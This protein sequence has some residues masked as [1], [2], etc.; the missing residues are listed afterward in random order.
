M[1]KI[2]IA[3]ICHFSNTNIRAK[4]PLS[5]LWV[6][7]L[8]KKLIGKNVSNYEDFAPW[9]TTI[10]SEFEKF[11]DVEL[12]VISPH[13]GLK[14]KLNEFSSNNIHYHFFKPVMPFIQIKWRSVFKNYSAPQYRCNREMVSQIVN[15][16]NPE[17]VN[18]FGSENPYYSIT[19]LDIKKIP[20]NVL[21]QSVLYTPFKEKYNFVVE[22]NRLEIERKIFQ[23]CFYFGTACRM[24]SDCVLNVNPEANIFE[25][26]FPTQLPP[27]VSSNRTLYDFV[28][29]AKSVSNIKGIEDTIKALA[30]VKKKKEDVKLNVIGSCDADYKEFLS[31]LIVDLGLKD[32]VTFHDYF[33][34]H[35]NMFEQVKRSKIAVLPNKLDVLSSTIREAMF[36]EMPIV[37]TVTT[38]TPY[39]NAD[40]QTVLLSEIGNIENLAHNMYK[41]LNDTALSCNLVKNAKTLAEKVFDNNAIAKKLVKDN[42]AILEN[43][44]EKKTI[45]KELLFKPDNYPEY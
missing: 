41:L 5:S 7:N 32:N 38:G 9:I 45:P 19:A 10:I 17:V 13:V 14:Y 29:F 30:L 33:P 44:K 39:L 42:I 26:W 22:E 11:E 20:V 35:K 40:K 21:L 25:F 27:K 16:I 34:E 12:H 3:F 18:L 24:Y 37:T 1:K 28:F 31:N 8:F 23:S 43:Y 15:Q 6:K 4:L 36:L 2:K